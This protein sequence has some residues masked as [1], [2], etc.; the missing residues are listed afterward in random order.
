MQNPKLCSI[1]GIMLQDLK[2]S[3]FEHF[4]AQPKIFLSCQIH[5]L[6]L[7]QELQ[8]ALGITLEALVMVQG[9]NH[10]C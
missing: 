7:T 6:H 3:D 4:D 8:S 9:Q 5:F 10:F 1:N 2:N